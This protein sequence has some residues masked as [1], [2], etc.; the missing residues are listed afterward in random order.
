[1]E[2]RCHLLCK[3]Q[4]EGVATNMTI[5]TI[6]YV[7]V[8]T[9]FVAYVMLALCDIQEGRYRTGVVSSLFAVVTWLIFI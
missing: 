9:I 3:G 7:V 4:T 6:R 5:K 2:F 8:M 1:M